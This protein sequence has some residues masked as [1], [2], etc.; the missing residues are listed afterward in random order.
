MFTFL[1][2]FMGYEN[3]YISPDSIQFDKGIER[4]DVRSRGVNEMG[5][6]RRHLH[7]DPTPWTY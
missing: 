4:R 2:I 1:V 3:Y 6:I 7:P 5:D